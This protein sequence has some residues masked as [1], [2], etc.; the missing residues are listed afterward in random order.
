MGEQIEP[1]Y[2]L[3]G[4]I[5][6]ETTGVGAVDKILSA[7]ARASRGYHNTSEWYEPMDWDEPPFTGATYRER[8]QNAANECAKELRRATCEQPGGEMIA[9]IQAVYDA[10]MAF[11]HAE[12]TSQEIVGELTDDLRNNLD[13][14]G[15]SLAYLRD[16]EP[17]ERW[18]ICPTCNGNGKYRVKED[19]WRPIKC[20]PCNGTGR[21]PDPPE[22]VEEHP[23]KHLVSKAPLTQDDIEWAHGCKEAAEVKNGGNE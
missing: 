5:D 1:K 8:I 15:L 6:F 9:A 18:T 14:L 16:S 23:L 2:N 17:A 13:T 11:F 20:G 3:N 7:V 4:N 21:L 19:G 10:G 12:A 22:A